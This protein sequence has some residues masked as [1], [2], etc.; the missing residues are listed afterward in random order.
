MFYFVEY[1]R[2]EQKIH[3]LRERMLTTSGTGSLKTSAIRTLYVR[4]ALLTLL[5]LIIFEITQMTDGKMHVKVF[6][7]IICNCQMLL[8]HDFVFLFLEHYLNTTEQR[9]VLY[10][11]RD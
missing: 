9:I 11:A 4:Y 1:N 6:C 2:F 5:C 3:D 7:E 10:R 8:D